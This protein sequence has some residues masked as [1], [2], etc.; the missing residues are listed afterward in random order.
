MIKEIREGCNAVHKSISE[1]TRTIEK[2][3]EFFKEENID[4]GFIVGSGTSFHASL[5]L[6]LLMSRFTGTSFIAVPASEFENWTPLA[7]SDHAIIAISQSGESSDVLRAVEEARKKGSFIIGITNTAGS[8]LTK[9]S[10]I[11]LITQAGKENAVT[12]TKTYDAQLA[13]V[14]YMAFALSDKAD[15]FLEKLKEVPDILYKV[16]N[17]ENEIHDTIIKYNKF[18]NIFILGGGVNYANALEAGLKFKEAAMIHAEG[19]A[20][21]EFLHGPIQLVNEETPVIIYLPTTESLARSKKT[22][23]KLV[24]YNAKVIAIAG[25]SVDVG[26]FATDVIQFPNIVEELSIFPVIKTVQIMAYYISVSR[27]LNPDNPSKL[28]KVVK[29]STE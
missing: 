9:L 21:R 4:K 10:D 2:V 7:D 1:N 18:N 26:N 22:I 13:V 23:E 6:S 12:A 8:S 25:D 14:C 19:F 15:V 28:T 24:N 16:I 17:K 29:Y 5:V 11:S 20:V 27:G 3:V